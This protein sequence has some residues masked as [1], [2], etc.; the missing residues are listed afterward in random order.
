MNEYN[1]I[2]IF[3]NAIAVSFSFFAG[4][5]VAHYTDEYKEDIPLGFQFL[6][7]GLITLFFSILAYYFTYL[8]FHYIPMS[9]I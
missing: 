8:V 5:I 9:K 3:S 1:W 6:I 7:T 4:Y 2:S